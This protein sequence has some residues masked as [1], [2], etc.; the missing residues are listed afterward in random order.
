MTAT[1][2]E[3]KGRAKVGAGSPSHVIFVL[4][5]LSR[6]MERLASRPSFSMNSPLS[7]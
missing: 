2:T 6:S 5:R 1:A 3:S 4:A 7:P